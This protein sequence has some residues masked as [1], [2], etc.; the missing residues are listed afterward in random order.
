ML[1]YPL[2]NAYLICGVDSGSAAARAS[3]P[4]D[5]ATP[6]SSEPYMIMENAAREARGTAETARRGRSQPGGG[7]SAGAG[8]G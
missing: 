3:D 4:E 5:F 2:R 6:P 8:A 1:T 7:Q